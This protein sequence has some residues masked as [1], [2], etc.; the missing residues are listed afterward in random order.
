MSKSWL[1]TSP[2]YSPKRSPKNLTRRNRISSVGKSP[3]KLSLDFAEAAITSDGRG[4]C[5][6]ASNS[7]RRPRSP[8]VIRNAKKLQQ[9]SPRQS[10]PNSTARRRMSERCQLFKSPGR[11]NTRSRRSEAIASELQRKRE[12]RTDDSIAIDDYTPR[13]RDVETDRH[14][15]CETME[16]ILCETMDISSTHS[17]ITVSDGIANNSKIPVAKVVAIESCALFDD[18]SEFLEKSP[19][20]SN[21]KLSLKRNINDFSWSDSW[22]DTSSLNNKL[23]KSD[24]IMKDNIQSIKVTSERLSPITRSRSKTIKASLFITQ[25]SSTPIS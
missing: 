4:V 9:T 22:L 18:S 20:D 10:K 19:N 16:N 2:K 24:S 11:P 7:E 25:S 21:K 5:V 13:I 8:S 17:V 6:D 15:L 23:I 14:V 3:R 12:Q 1:S